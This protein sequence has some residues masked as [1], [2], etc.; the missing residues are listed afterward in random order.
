[1]TRE[2]DFVRILIAAP[3]KAGN[4]WLKCLLGAIYELEWIKHGEVPE[5][6]QVDELRAWLARGGFRDGTIFHQHF[7]YSDEFC[8]V[9]AA[10]PA[11]LVTIIRDPYDMFVSSY[12]TMQ[13]HIGTGKRTGPRADALMGKPLDHPEVLAFLRADGYRPNLVKAHEWLHSGRAVVL[14]YEELHRDP[15]EALRRATEQV[16]PVPPDRIARAVEQCSAER[17]RQRSRGM[18][19]HVRAATVGDSRNHLTSEHLTIFR[20]RYADLIRALGYETR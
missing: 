4:M 17:M 15:H 16:T 6:P 3:A 10:V 5:R 14:R 19:K 8:D 18:A 20:E 2:T 7:D 11:H 1:M 9:V 13:Q 12:F